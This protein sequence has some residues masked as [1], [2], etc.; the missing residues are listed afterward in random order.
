MKAYGVMECELR[1]MSRGSDGTHFRVMNGDFISPNQRNAK[2]MSGG[3]GG[4][5]FSSK[6]LVLGCSGQANL[7]KALGTLGMCYRL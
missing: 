7:P 5:S 4:S 1:I 2:A 6:G 3:G